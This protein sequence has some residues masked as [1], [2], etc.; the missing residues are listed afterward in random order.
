[1]CHFRLDHDGE[2]SVPNASL[3]GREGEGYM[4]ILEASEEESRQLL[5]EAGATD[6]RVR[7]IQLEEFFLQER[8]EMLIDWKEIFA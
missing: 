7:P 8:K 3:M 5:A 1:N 4:C 6:I 2:P